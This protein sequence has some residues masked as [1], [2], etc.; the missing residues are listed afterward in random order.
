[1]ARKLQYKISQEFDNIKIQNF[2]RL[3]NG[4]ST[5]LIRTLK[6]SPDGILLNGEHARAVDFIHTGDLLEINIPDEKNEI[7]AS[8]IEIDVVYEDEDILVVNKSPFLAMHPSHNHQG[9]TLANAVAYHLKQ[10]G[11]ECT[12][13]AIGRLDKGTSG[14]VVI[15]LNQLAACR[16]SGNIE[17]HY[18]ALVKGK[19]TGKG[20]VDVPIYRPNPLKTL[21]ACDYELG[22]ESAVT[23]WQALEN[24]ENSTLVRLDLETGRT[25]QIR[26]HMAHIGHPLAGDSF[27]GDFQLHHSH[28]LLHCACVNFFHPIT[29]EKMM[30]EAKEKF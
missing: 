23:H 1:M 14:L 7:E 4:Y 12:F 22:T 8:P 17:K 29:N 24:Y 16:L 2:L 26:V 27:Y 6:T 11:K 9:D 5:K 3:H 21:R 19:L 10:Q 13:R 25:H 28:Q 20:T 18:V 30:I 15:A